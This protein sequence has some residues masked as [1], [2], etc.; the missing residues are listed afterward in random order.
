MLSFHSQRLT[1]AR[2]P[3]ER[4]G[5]RISGGVPA[6][7]QD[8]ATASNGSL[9]RCLSSLSNDGSILVT[10]ISS[11]GAVG[12]DGRLKPGDRLLEVNGHWMMGSTLDEALAVSDLV[13]TVSRF[14]ASECI[15]HI[16]AKGSSR[17]QYWWGSVCTL[18]FITSVDSCG[19]A[20]L[21]IYN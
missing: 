4:F 9:S 2:Q 17:K 10:W 19:A 16:L 7:S 21:T 20:I 11:D 12:R 13:I 14:D 8:G 3:G 1:I 15:H 18:F 6:S 5:L